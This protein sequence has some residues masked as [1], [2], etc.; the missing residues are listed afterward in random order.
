MKRKLW[1]ALILLGGLAMAAWWSLDDFR[2]RAVTLA[3][4]GFF[5]V[6]IL[7]S[8]AHEVSEER[9]RQD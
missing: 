4:L 9:G 2:F 5:A 8:N 1:L 6:R 7:M 3:V